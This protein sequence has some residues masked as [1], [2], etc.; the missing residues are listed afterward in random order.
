LPYQSQSL[1]DTCEEKVREERARGMRRGEEERRGRREEKY[2]VSATKTG[3][4]YL[5]WSLHQAQHNTI[6]TARVQKGL[7]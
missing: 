5:L 2:S 7:K 4:T 1:N 6:S 3:L